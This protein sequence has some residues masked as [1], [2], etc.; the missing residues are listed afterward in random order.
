MQLG[1]QIAREGYNYAST[2]EDDILRWDELDADQ[3][4]LFSEAAAHGLKSTLRDGFVPLGC[5]SKKHLRSYLSI[6]MEGPTNTVSR[7]HA[8]IVGFDDLYDEVRALFLGA[9][10]APAITLD[11]SATEIRNIQ[12]E[13]QQ[14]R[15]AN[16]THREAISK[17]QEDLAASAKR[18]EQ[19][20]LDAMKDAG[21]MQRPRNTIASQKD[22]A[23]QLRQAVKD[24]LKEFH[25]ESPTDDILDMVRSACESDVVPIPHTKPWSVKTITP[26]T[27]CSASDIGGHDIH[28]KE[29]TVLS[30]REE[31]WQP[32]HRCVTVTTTELGYGS[33]TTKV[34]HTD[35]TVPYLVG[36]IH[37][38]TPPTRTE[39]SGAEP[40]WRSD[41]RKSNRAFIGLMALLT[42]IGIAGVIYH[43]VLK[44]F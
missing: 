20:G 14:L 44:G 33:N 42:I 7:C 23:E 2:R 11:F 5:P 27:G 31:V 17:L 9:R 25:I 12:S 1:E 10:R 41:Y 16:R 6:L 19:A 34:E 32:S 36:E 24:I 29:P 38:A 28:D 40:A 26:L 43:V 39:D 37:P 30:E 8:R 18:N 35:Y 3:K 15:E 21:E 4:L 22:T 13:N